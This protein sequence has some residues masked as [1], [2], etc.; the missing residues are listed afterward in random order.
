MVQTWQFVSTLPSGLFGDFAATVT[1]LVQLQACYDE[2]M[3]RP[4]QLRPCR[5]D[6][7]ALRHRLRDTAYEAEE[8]LDRVQ[9]KARA[10]TEDLYSD[11]SHGIVGEDDVDWSVAVVQLVAPSTLVQLCA[12]GFLGEDLVM[13]KDLGELREGWQ[14]CGGLALAAFAP[15]AQPIPLRSWHAA[16]ESIRELGHATGFTRS[17][18]GEHFAV[19]VP[20]LDA[21]AYQM[22]VLEAWQQR[23]ERANARAEVD[24]QWD[25]AENLRC[26]LERERARL[27]S[28]GYDPKTSDDPLCGRDLAP[29]HLERRLP[30]Q[31]YRSAERLTGFYARQEARKKDRRRVYTASKAASLEQQVV[32]GAAVNKSQAGD[33][34][35]EAAAAFWAGVDPTL[36]MPSAGA[37]APA[38][39]Q[40]A[41]PNTDLG[42]SLASQH[43]V[44]TATYTEISPSASYGGASGIQS[45]AGATPANASASSPVSRVAST[46]ALATA[47][48]PVASALPAPTTTVAEMAASASWADME[49]RIRRL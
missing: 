32:P 48:A 39:G 3:A 42:A 44:S 34:A 9:R 47:P 24:R 46:F 19:L 11:D 15:L 1:E 38:A 14:L 45:F 28:K 25:A 43:S 31:E 41:N 5:C 7:C 26:S 4:K 49:R 18:A 6:V 27:A 21:V 29:V 17:A 13:L 37:T 10:M 16:R 33:P 35:Y 23:V 36:A 12:P 30:L 20:L 40:A 22:Q 2:V 8:L